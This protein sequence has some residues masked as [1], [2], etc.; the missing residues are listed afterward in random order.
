M[1]VFRY[2]DPVKERMRNILVLD[3]E[4]IQSAEARDRTFDKRIVYFVMC[5]SH[6]VLICNKSEMNAQMT[7]VVKL[8][9]DAI[10]NTKEVLMKNPTILIIMNMMPQVKSTTAQE[11]MD[12]LE[13]N[14]S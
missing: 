14:F 9:A 8:V 11:C 7:D 1:S 6:V 3:S 10:K 2:F 4:G 12:A 13:R 5:V